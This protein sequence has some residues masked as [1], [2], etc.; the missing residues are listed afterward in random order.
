MSRASLEI[1]L[2]GSSLISEP[3]MT[4]V[5]SSRRL[6][7]LRAMRVLAWPRSPRKIMSWPARIAFSICGSTV[8]S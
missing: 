2:Y 4:G 3:A 5:N 6:I 7:R 1:G 8:S